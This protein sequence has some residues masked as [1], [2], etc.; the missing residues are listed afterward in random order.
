MR[1]L[2]K[3]RPLTPHRGAAD[4]IKR[5]MIRSPAVLRG[6]NID[7][8]MLLQVHDELI[9]EVPEE[10]TVVSVAAITRIMAG[11][12]S[13]PV[14]ESTLVVEAG[15]A[16]AGQ[17]RTKQLAGLAFAGLFALPRR[18]QAVFYLQFYDTNKMFLSEQV[19]AR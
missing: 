16:I 12:R 3:D 8:D 15:I 4:I 5:A 18:N 10:Q 9:F 19:E 14:L 2:P 1:A 13:R 6:K 17:K 11:G 7:A